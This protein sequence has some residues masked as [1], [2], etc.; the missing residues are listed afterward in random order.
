MSAAEDWVRRE[1][2]LVNAHGLHARPSALLVKEANRFQA[3][4]IL[5][6]GGR[7]ADAKSMMEVIMLASPVGT[8]IVIAARGVDADEAVEALV[9]LIEGGFGDTSR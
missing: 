2:A 3:R 7:E 4:L 9:L 8:P 5:T 6:I 1:T